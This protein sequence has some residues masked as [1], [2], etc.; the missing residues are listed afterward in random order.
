ME[1]T[2]YSASL[3]HLMHLESPAWE[4]LIHKLTAVAHEGISLAHKIFI[5]GL[6]FI[7]SNFFLKISFHSYVVCF[8]SWSF[9]GPQVLDCMWACTGETDGRCGDTATNSCPWQGIQYLPIKDM[10][11]VNDLSDIHYMSC[12]R[13]FNSARVNL[14]ATAVDILETLILC[15]QSSATSSWCC[16]LA[17]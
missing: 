7:S 15:H 13:C 9:F 4:Q 5:G 2:V 14:N 17:C 12:L 10:T 3:G 16:S 6:P 11:E 8:L 1:C